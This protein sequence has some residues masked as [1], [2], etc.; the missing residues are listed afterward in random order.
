MVHVG[1]K[2]TMANKVSVDVHE[3]NQILQILQLS[4]SLDDKELQDIAIEGVIDKLK[5]FIDEK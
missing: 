3:L 1:Q 4:L 2:I 5:Q